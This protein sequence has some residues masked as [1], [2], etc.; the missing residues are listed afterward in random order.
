MNTITWLL[1]NKAQSSV[2]TG[3]YIYVIQVNNGY[4]VSTRTGKLIVFH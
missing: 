2:A 1:K 4:E 3:L